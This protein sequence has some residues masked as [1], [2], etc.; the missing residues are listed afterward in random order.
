MVDIALLVN[1]P[2]FL[3]KQLVFGSDNLSFFIYFNGYFDVLWL[4][5]KVFFLQRGLHLILQIKIC[6]FKY[7]DKSFKRLNNAFKIID[8]VLVSHQLVLVALDLLVGL[9]QI[10]VVG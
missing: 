4:A 8:S 9:V 6:Y 2:R 1:K 3:I 5:L 7:A 10:V